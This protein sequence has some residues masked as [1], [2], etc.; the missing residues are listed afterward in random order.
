MTTVDPKQR[1]TLSE[2]TEQMKLLQP[3]SA[4]SFKKKPTTIGQIQFCTSHIIG[5]GGQASV[6]LGFLKG[7]AVAVKRI[8]IDAVEGDKKSNVYRERE[9]FQKLKHRNIVKLIDCDENCT[10]M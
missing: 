7:S 5:I 10:F 1:S 3:P 4:I 9:S 8:T 6:F 2:I